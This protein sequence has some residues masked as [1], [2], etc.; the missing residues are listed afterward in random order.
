MVRIAQI[1]FVVDDLEQGLA[2]YAHLLGGDAWRCYT[3]GSAIHTTAEYRGASAEFSAR[4]ALNDQSPQIEL[5]EPLDGASIHR[6]WL[7]DGGVGVHHVG[8]V[9]DSVAA[10]VEEMA[11]D[12]YPVI[13]GG[14]G[15]GAAGDGAYAYFDTRDR[16][17]VITEVFEPPERMHPPDA[18]WRPD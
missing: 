17:G 1:A 15:F 7:A 11:R 10:V 3:F 13:Q 2:R 16:L 18:I 8:R 14:T 9:V 5:I 12:G 4:L 6:D